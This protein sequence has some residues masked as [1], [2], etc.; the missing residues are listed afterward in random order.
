MTIDDIFLLKRES[1]SLHND[2]QTKTTYYLKNKKRFAADL[3]LNFEDAIYLFGLA[4]WHAK[5]SEK[6]E[7][8]TFWHF[9]V[10][11]VFISAFGT[12][13]AARTHW[14][15]FVYAQKDAISAWK[16]SISFYLKL[17]K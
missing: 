1:T 14:Y 16:S 3:H 7:T 11:P 10:F 2:L 4:R 15:I 8:T 5:E 17:K 9:L 12:E 6:C 13:S